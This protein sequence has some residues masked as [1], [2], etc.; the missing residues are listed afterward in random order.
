MSNRQ[1]NVNRDI[2][3]KL[4]AWFRH[5]KRDLPWRNT[6]DPYPI[7]VS[8]I[9]LQQTRVDT[10][11]PYYNRFLKRFPTIQRLAKAPL[12]E[13]LKVWEG[14]GYYARARNLQKAAQLITA[15][16]KGKMPER[17]ED[18]SS[19]PGIGRYTAGAICSIAFG[20]KVPV[21][22]GNVIR[23]LARLYAI[24]ED[25]KKPE[26]NRK[27]WHLATDL[28]P[29]KNPGDLNQSLME[30][31]ATLC[32]P[33]NPSCIICPVNTFCMAYKEGLSN[34][35]PFKKQKKKL[36]HYNISA[37]VIWKGNKILIG[38][39]PLNGLLGGLWEFPGGKQEKE[40]T[41]QQC[42]KR[43]IKEELDI[44]IKV[45]K[46]IMKVNHVYSHFAITLHVFHARYLKGTPKKIGCVDFKWV[47]PSQLRQY[48]FPAA[49]QP[50]IEFLLNK[51]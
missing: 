4:L 7:W 51:N 18:V 24:E 8:E 17:F 27:L 3:K 25:P 42:L 5:N 46:F 30:L 2:Q 26:T 38:Q 1:P 23:V 41:L 50:I 12:D 28:L 34:S 16:H 6:T 9:M 29:N 33:Q 21:L 20:M 15:H 13:V 43:E 36:P 49:N 47:S 45:Q 11:I 48:A 44:D 14:L 19:L 10:V 37:G 22:D 31:G 39:R 35:I 32:S 40:E